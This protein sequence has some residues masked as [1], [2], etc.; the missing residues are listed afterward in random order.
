MPDNH[1]DPGLLNFLAG[2]EGFQIFKLAA[3][4]K[5]HRRLN[6]LFLG[7]P[8]RFQLMAFMTWFS[9]RLTLFLYFLISIFIGIFR[10]GLIVRA[11]R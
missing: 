7:R 2:A 4:A 3:S 9:A 8:E 1:F 6:P 5:A 11:V 10:A